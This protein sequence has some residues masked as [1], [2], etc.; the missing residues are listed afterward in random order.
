MQG[1]GSDMSLQQEE[2]CPASNHEL[3]EVDIIM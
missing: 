3:H 2:D 1:S